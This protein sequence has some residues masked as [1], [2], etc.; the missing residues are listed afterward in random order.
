MSTWYVLDDTVHPSD[1]IS[2]DSWKECMDADT[3]RDK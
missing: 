1:H 2:Q 3:G